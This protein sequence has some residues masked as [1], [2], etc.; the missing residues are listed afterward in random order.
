MQREKLTISGPLL[1]A[2]FY[3]VFENGRRMPTRA[4]KTKIST[5]EQQRYN[6]IMATKKLIRLV[7]ANFDSSD[8]W[9]HPTYEPKYA[10]QSEEQA[11][12]DI[13]NY[14][15]R[16]KTKRK[17]LLN[18]LEKKLKSAKEALKKMPD[19]AFILSSVED[20]KAQISKLKAPFKYVYV[21]EKQIYKTG[22]Y[23]GLVNWHFHLFLTGGI[24]DKM[25]EKMW[26]KG[27][28]A[29]CDNYQ[30][31]KFGP[32]AA[33]KYMSK[34]PQGS[35]RFSYS[36]NLEQPNEKTKDGR[37]SRNTVARM[38]TER[39]DDRE[40]WERRY[41][42]YRFIRCYNRFNEYNGHW[43]VTAVMYKTDG[44]PPKWEQD[45]WITT[46]YVSASKEMIL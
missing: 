22:I 46:D 32:E 6:T 10:P 4:P 13:V 36:R 17:S 3:P 41:K 25:L 21:I 8:Y 24:D 30:P 33:A 39:I 31:D 34:D 23:A 45:E 1:E 2:D 44:D 15:R 7:N 16:V 42:G 43:Y 29:N 19:N 14:L 9:M 12:R 26:P 27:L 18:Q 20:V 5:R 28:R 40:Y 38:A 11:R 35:K 37:V